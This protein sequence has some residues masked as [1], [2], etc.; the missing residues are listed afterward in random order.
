[1][2][3]LFKHTLLLLAVL[4]LPS[5]AHSQDWVSKMQDPNTNYF[6]VRDAF[7]EYYDNYVQTY[8]QQHGVEP[9]RVPGHKQFRRWEWFVKPRVNTDGSRFNPAK[10]FMEAQQYKQQFSTA[11]AGNWSLIGPSVVPSNGG[12]AGRLNVVR[13]H[14]TNPNII[15]V[16]SPGGGLW[17]STD[18]GAT[19]ASNTDNLAAV[20]GCTDLAI[21]PNN[22]DIM[23]LATGDGFGASTY[24]VG[25]LKTTDGGAT[26]NTTGLS[27]SNAA[28]RQISRILIDPTNTSTILA[29]ASNGIYRSTDAGATWNNVQTGGF[30]DM[31]F[32]PGDPN[33]IY[34]SG[35]E[36]Y[37]ST[38]NG[39]SWTKVTSGLPIASNVSRI[40]T[41]VTPA[42]PAVV[43]LIIGLPAPNYG[44]EGFYRS[45]NS[46]VSFT[47]QSTPALGNQQWY[48]LALNASTSNADEV[49][50]GGQ[51][52]F[53]RSTNAGVSWSQNGG[54]THVDYHD[55][56]YTGN[57]EY[58]MTNDGGIYRTTNSG[59][60][61][62]N[63][64][65]GLEIA[66]IY[67]FGQ[68]STV[69]DLLITGWQDNGTNRASGNGWQH[70]YGGDGMLCFIDRTNNNN[71]WASTQY[72]GF[73]RSTNSGGTWSN[74]TTGIT[75]TASAPWVTSWMQ[76]P[77]NASTLYA[78][79]IN[80][81]KSTNGA[82]SWT[83]ISSF[84]TT[85]TVITLGISPANNQVIWASKPDGLYRTTNGGGSWTKMTGI[86]SG[87]IT[88]IACSDTDANK[89]WITYSGF[90]NT[91]KVFMTNDQGAT[92]INI[93]ASI[94]NVP[95]NCIV[96]QNNSNDGIYIG[97]DLGVFYKDNSL[98][99]WE[100]F[101]SGLPNV[102]VTQLSIFYAGG[103]IRA[104]TY[105]RGMWES[106]LWSGGTFAPTAAF[107]SDIRIA[108]PGTLVN[109]SDY[110]AG[111]PTS[112][113]WTFQGGNPSS[114]TAQN[115]QVVYNTPGTYEVTLV[116][117][118]GNGNSTS[119]Q[120]GY[121][122]ITAS[123]YN[124]PAATGAQRCGA[125]PVT[126]NAS[127]TGLGV[128][129]WWD[130]AGGGTQVATGSTFNTSITG[131]TSYWVDETFPN[132][133]P[134]FVGEFSNSVGAGAFF[135]A[136]DIRGLYFDVL[137]PVVINSVEV[138]SNSAGDRTIEV[139]D[140]QGN[141]V[142][143]KVVF[144][145]ASPNQPY[146][147]PLNI[148]M[149]PGT[150]YF[151][152]CRGLVDLYRNSSGPVY[153]Y[154]SSLIN[155][156]NSNAGSPGYYYFFYNWI[157]TEITCNTARTQV[158]AEDTCSVGL[159]DVFINGSFDI[160]P[161]PSKGKFE[162]MFNVDNTSDV[163]VRVLNNLGQAVIREEI[164][165][166]SGEF[167]RSYD[168][169]K[170][171]AGIYMIEIS[172]GDSKVSRKLVIN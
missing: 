166:H 136:N 78:G 97:T 139:I 14:P 162:L 29:A 90:S 70:V 143:E 125:G 144:I 168:L 157:Y 17:K 63:L 2:K 66:Q 61:W 52:D 71:M 148:T 110:S 163:T 93:S 10:V 30:K 27:Y 34:A 138:Y 58:Y 107:T 56:V 67:G 76:D 35:V 7:Q 20:I 81:W 32:K 137:A 149:Y 105:G 135:T 47:K 15:F 26:W 89:A 122:T 79:F 96:Y 164:V 98:N 62:T 172:S 161:N 44:T 36:F 102:V 65:D 124:A 85:G 33:T 111:S 8:R 133:N 91:N 158:I 152:K 123:P 95:V 103:K 69:P 4:I 104:S 43:Y 129:R 84:Q 150:D 167:R 156:T 77:V 46:G 92:W 74:A 23:Y 11:N 99:V 22:P 112:W 155:I 171:G 128:L 169:T 115:P 82:Q 120:T 121:I 109:F 48:D 1:M 130:S 141:T 114:S 154:T 117:T 160:F 86:P 12:G 19:W 170:A 54:N 37:R 146:T 25:I 21:D 42:N 151:I 9:A 39:Q 5:I 59:G 31:E 40:A 18:G 153:P 113:Q 94:P 134:D 6:E 132:G 28:Y 80:V 100:P 60:S 145:P 119:T 16:C 57:T 41:A 64:S 118:N 140:S 106:D 24:T 131:T 38:N 126:L 165:K 88:G 3:S 83:K 45:T 147:V 108:C 116:A 159:N 75:E 87:T 55:V 73:V 13:F 142:V 72:G 101:W 127:G 51:L 53:R 49:I 68:S 50:V